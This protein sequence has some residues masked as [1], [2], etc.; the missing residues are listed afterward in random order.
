MILAKPKSEGPNPTA[1][2]QR[3]GLYQ[4]CRIEV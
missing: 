2:G 1:K 3:V 4:K